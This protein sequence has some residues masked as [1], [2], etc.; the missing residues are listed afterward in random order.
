MKFMDHERLGFNYRLTDV[1]AALGIAQ[2]ERLDDMLAAR[3]AVAADYSAAA[4]PRS[5]PPS[6]A[7]AIPTTWSCRSPTAAPSG[8]AGS[9][10][11]CG[12]R[13]RSTATA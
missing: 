1:Q 8:A 4:S 2:L 9:S 13:S 6:R 3:A 7:T 11:S 10:T 12:C 5:A